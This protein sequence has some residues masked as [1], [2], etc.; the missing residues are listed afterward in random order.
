MRPYVCLI[1][2]SLVA[3]PGTACHEASSPPSGRDGLGP[4]PTPPAVPVPVPV[5]SRLVQVVDGDT[6][7]AVAHARVTLPDT[8]QVTDAA[9]VAALPM[10]CVPAH[11]DA[12]GFLERRVKCLLLTTKD[13]Q[14]PITLW[15]VADEAEREALKALAFRN[16]TRLTAGG[17]GSVAVHIDAAV[18]VEAVVA[19]WQRA[20]ETVHAATGGVR[21]VTFVTAQQLRDLDEGFLVR[22]AAD[23]PSCSHSWFTWQFNVAGFC[24]DATLDYFIQAVTVAPAFMAREDVALRALLYGMGLNPHPLSG[25]MNVTQPATRLSAFELRTLRMAS[26]REGQIAWPDFEL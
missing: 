6:G 7:R 24:W 25:L 26:Q 5:A 11:I 16:G 23:P 22:P 18:G 1:V 20:A 13:G 3:T 19:A 10:A 21:E 17:R 4:S 14:Q 15:P 8:T 2:L 12:V 9:G